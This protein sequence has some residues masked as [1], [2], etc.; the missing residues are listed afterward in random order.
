MPKIEHHGPGF[1]YLVKYRPKDSDEDWTEA[2][3]ENPMESEVSNAIPTHTINDLVQRQKTI[4]Q[5][6]RNTINALMFESIKLKFTMYN[7]YQKQLLRIS[8]S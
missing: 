4:S 5:Q 3:I 2:K 6:T 1:H 7:G 8:P